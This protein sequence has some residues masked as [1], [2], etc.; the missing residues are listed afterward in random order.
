MIREMVENE[1]KVY[2]D[3]K[4]IPTNVRGKCGKV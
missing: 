4:H 1:D 2:Q 3:S